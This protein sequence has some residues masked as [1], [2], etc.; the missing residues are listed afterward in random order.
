MSDI[1][2]Q[3]YVMGMLNNVT[4]NLVRP[5]YANLYNRDVKRC[6]ELKQIM[7]RFSE[8]FTERIAGP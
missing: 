2:D 8:E 6:R 5:S 7:E 3:A 4:V 1:Y